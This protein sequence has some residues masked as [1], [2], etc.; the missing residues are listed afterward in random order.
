M[1]VGLGERLAIPYMKFDLIRPLSKFPRAEKMLRMVLFTSV[2]FTIFSLIPAAIIMQF[3]G[4]TYLEAW[5]YTIVT[6]TTVGF[7]DYVPGGIIYHFI[8]YCYAYLFY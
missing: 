7:G 6:L 4:W 1:L 3:E 5:Y 2:C 8:S